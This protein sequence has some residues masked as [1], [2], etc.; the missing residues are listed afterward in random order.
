MKFKEIIEKLMIFG[1]CKLPE[2]QWFLI[3]LSVRP[4][5]IL[6]MSAHLELLILW[7]R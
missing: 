2:F 4:L 6:A 3:E 1:E 7:W 5:R